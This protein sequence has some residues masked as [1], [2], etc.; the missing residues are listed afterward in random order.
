M[1]P[2]ICLT[3]GVEYAAA[4]DP[5]SRCAICEDERQYVGWEGQRWTTMAQLRADGYRNEI[6]DEAPGLTGIG[7]TPAFSIGQR[8]LLVQT[9]AGNILFDCVSYLDDETVRAITARGGIQGICLSHPH[10]YDSMVS[11]SHAFDGAPIYIPQADR[12]WVMRPD[13]VIRYW[14]GEPLELLPGLTLIQCGGH[15]P[16]SAVLH[17]ADGADG[18]GALLAGDSITVALDRRHVSFMYSYPNLVPLSAAQVRRI[19]AAVESYPF[20]H[21]YGAW[22]NRNILAGAKEA[23]RRSVARYVRRIETP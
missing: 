4:D 12:E 16:G 21:I 15:F 23:V 13:P 14:D 22:W 17:W 2:Y 10:F 11:W 20:D 5:P 18:R 6:R 8:A 19:V 1:Q 3:C 7:I 9:G